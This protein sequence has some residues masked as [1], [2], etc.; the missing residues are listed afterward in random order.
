MCTFHFSPLKSIA[1]F[2]VKIATRGASFQVKPR[3]RPERE[4]RCGLNNVHVLILIKMRTKCT[5]SACANSEHYS[6]AQGRI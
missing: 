5:V 1:T 6:N 4:G 3:V 2:T